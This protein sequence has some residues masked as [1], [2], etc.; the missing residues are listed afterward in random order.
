MTD[1]ISPTIPQAQGLTQNFRRA[2]C[3]ML[4]AATLVACNKTTQPS[5]FIAPVADTKVR[6]DATTGMSR[7]GKPY[8]VKGVGGSDNLKQLASRGANSIRTWTTGGLAA[9][10]AE[11]DKFGLT[12]SAGIWL[13][14]ECSWFSYKNPSHC[15]KQAE[16]VRKEVASFRDHPALLAWGLGNE[17]EGDGTNSAYWKQLDRLALLVQE[18]DPTHPTYTAVAGLSPAKAD[19][20]NAH[21]PHLDYVGINTYGGVPSLRQHLEKTGW[22]RPWMLTEWGPRGFWESP[23]S[24]SGAP[25]EQTSSEKATMMR[26]AY[27]KAISN[28]HGCMGSYAFVWGWKFEATCTWFGLFTLEG[29]TTAAVDTL[30]ELWT[31]TKPINQAPAIKDLRGVPKSFVEAGTTFEASV[32]ATDPDGDP[33]V[34][35]WAVLPEQQTGKQMPK[36]IPNTIISAADNQASVTVP[37]KRGT[38]RLHVWIKDGK[39]HAA[40]ANLPF[41]VR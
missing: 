11:A 7:G 8:F 31:A 30:Q 36:P 38:Y 26:Q 37:A 28:D 24:A 1:S 16:R 4:A 27:Q 32:Q 15:D 19:G 40:T 13:E 3:I 18:I 6:V 2:A 5:N 12:V 29:D 14:P 17:A 35:Q 23:K 39:G 33:L 9:I 10:L 22:K 25:L 41:E 20:M 21:A 34:W